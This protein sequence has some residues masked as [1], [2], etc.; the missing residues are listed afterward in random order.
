MSPRSRTRSAAAFVIAIASLVSTQARSAAAPK[1]LPVPIVLS[2]GWLMQ[3]IAE[4]QESGATVSSLEFNPAVFRPVPYVPPPTADANPPAN[5]GANGADRP[6]SS[7]SWQQAPAPS[8]PAWYRATVPGTGLTTLANNHIYPE[9]LYGENNRP[10]I[11]PESLCR[12]S[13]WYRTEF[14]V[15]S[16][17][18]HDRVW[19]NFEGINYM[20]EVWVNTV[21]AGEIRG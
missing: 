13:Y 20:A 19:L 8:S 6:K 11:I 17:Y 14:V 7:S 21:K 12:T 2:S 16:T 3:D 10:N 1:A 18:A 9:P 5:P 4:V 15:P